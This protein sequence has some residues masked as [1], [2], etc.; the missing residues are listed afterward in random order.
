MGCDSM[1]EISVHLQLVCFFHFKIQ[2]GNGDVLISCCSGLVDSGA[3]AGL[4]MFQWT[5]NLSI[6]ST[7][8]PIAKII[9]V[10]WMFDRVFGISALEALRLER[11]GASKILLD[12]SS[13]RGSDYPSPLYFVRHIQT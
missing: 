9:S 1:R 12:Q 6:K 13:W 5:A 4:F 3:K 8:L 10:P 7:F 2:G 11:A